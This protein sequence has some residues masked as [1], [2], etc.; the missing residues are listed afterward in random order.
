LK[1]GNRG[2]SDDV[3]NKTE[4]LGNQV[5]CLVGWQ[6]PWIKS[7]SFKIRHLC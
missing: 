7:W 5:S 3:N 1:N 4:K 6:S 2:K